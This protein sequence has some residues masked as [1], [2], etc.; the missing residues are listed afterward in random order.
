MWPFSTSKNLTSGQIAQRVRDREA[1]LYHRLGIDGDIG[2]S[3]LV[4]MNTLLDRVEDL[5]DELDRFVHRLEIVEG[6]IDDRF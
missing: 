3:L 5:E 2:D 1:A 6:Q 4:V